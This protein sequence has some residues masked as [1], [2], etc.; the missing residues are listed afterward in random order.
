[1]EIKAVN[2]A[3]W[4]WQEETGDDVW[5]DVNAYTVEQAD[6]YT[7]QLKLTAE[8]KRKAERWTAWAQGSHTADY[9]RTRRNCKARTSLLQMLWSTLD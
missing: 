9:C 6:G 5:T 8:A 4:A 2:V 3:K 1:M 7:S